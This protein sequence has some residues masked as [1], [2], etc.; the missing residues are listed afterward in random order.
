MSI[1]NVILD[2]MV[3]PKGCDYEMECQQSFNRSCLEETQGVMRFIGDVRKD[4]EGVCEEQW[5]TL[6]I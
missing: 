6:G 3:S 1:R 2:G 5:N 4:L